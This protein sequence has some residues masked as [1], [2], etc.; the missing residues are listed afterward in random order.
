MAVGATQPSASNGKVAG[1]ELPWYVTVLNLI[2]L[3]C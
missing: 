2:R 3:Q 1:Y